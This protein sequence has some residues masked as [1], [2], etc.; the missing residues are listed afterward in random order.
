MRKEQS[1]RQNNK[2]RLPPKLESFE[3]CSARKLQ[4]KSMNWRNWRSL[5][6]RESMKQLRCKV[7]YKRVTRGAQ[8]RKKIIG[9]GNYELQRQAREPR[10]E[11]AVD[12]QSSSNSYRVEQSQDLLPQTLVKA[13]C[14]KK[15]IQ[16]PTSIS[17]SN[18]SS[19]SSLRSRTTYIE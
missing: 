16:S 3:V 11:I 6:C 15:E 13:P 17:S 2:M 12:E 1:L 19:K 4:K 9:H 14:I 7:K 8:V 18:K 10:L 5:R